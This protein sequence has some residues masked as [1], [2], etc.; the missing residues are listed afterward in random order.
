M[1]KIPVILDTDIGDDVDDTWALIMLLNSP[2]LE[3][4]MVLSATGD[5]VDRARIA[6]KLLELGGRTDVDVAVGKN[7]PPH[8]CNQH[9][10]AADY[11]L[12]RYPGRVH[13]DGVGAMIN[14]VMSSAVPVTLIAI[15]P[16]P[17]LGAALEREPR[18][19][20]KIRF[21]GM[22]GSLRMGYNGSPE[23]CAETNVRLYT[24]DC[25]KVFQA[26]WPMTITPLDTCGLVAFDGARY[27]EIFRRKTPLTN[28]LLENCRLF[29]K[30]ASWIKDLDP[31]TQSSVLF[32][33][34]AVWLAFS[35][36]YLNMEEL[37]VLVTD[38]GFTRIDPAGKTMRCATSWS[39]L[40][41]F[42]NELAKR[43]R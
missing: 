28:A 3:L 18:I 20:Q 17:N 36:K 42:R 14:L 7:F 16:T 21:I 23:P 4:K 29:A 37:P 32:D 15:A 8:T 2:E 40:E 31:E 5:A 38:D 11:D 41:G 35:E 34:V 27:A 24:A 10:W 19:A 26:A 43:I 6:A 12:S 25:R 22:H 1:E 30:N 13:E 39:D 33:T 9:D